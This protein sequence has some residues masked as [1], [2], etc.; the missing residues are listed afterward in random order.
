M[1]TGFDE[2]MRQRKAA[3]DAFVNGDAGPLERI[4]ARQSPATLFGPRGDVVNGASQVIEANTRGAAQFEP[5]A[6][7]AFEVLHSA[8]SDTLAYWTGLQRSTIVRGGERV[9]M[10]L[11]VTEI[12]RRDDGEWRL[13]HRHA[14]ELKG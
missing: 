8:S 7:N 2:F 5:G 13:V 4:S 12:F 14:D 11:R 6:S 9:A 1:D 3:S 10:T